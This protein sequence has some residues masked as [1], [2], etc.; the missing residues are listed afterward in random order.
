MRFFDDKLQ[1][2]DVIL[3]TDPIQMSK[4]KNP[5][6]VLEIEPI[7]SRWFVKVE[8]MKYEGAIKFPFNH[9]KIGEILKLDVS[10]LYGWNVKSSPENGEA[11]S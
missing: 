6:K 5:L 11:I 4:F 9:N 2:S 3:P 1:V 8:I 10:T 7:G